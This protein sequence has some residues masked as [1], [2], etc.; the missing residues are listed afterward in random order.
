MLSTK[1]VA[2]T[3]SKTIGAKSAQRP[4]S[5][6]S[7]KSN[8]AA[9]SSARQPPALSLSPTGYPAILPYHLPGILGMKHVCVLGAHMF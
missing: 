1:A 3:A 8:V 7:P 9:A 6:H 4:A 2:Q 5:H